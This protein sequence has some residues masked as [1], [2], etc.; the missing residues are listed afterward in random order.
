MRTERLFVQYQ[1]TPI[2]VLWHPKSNFKETR[3]KKIVIDIDSNFY[4]TS[5]VRLCISV[6]YENLV[7][8]DF[9]MEEIWNRWQN[10]LANASII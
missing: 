4:T 7:S 2:L 9:K 10:W 5:S 3:Y 6:G 1:P 8:P